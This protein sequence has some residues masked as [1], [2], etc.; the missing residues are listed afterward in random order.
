MQISELGDP[1]LEALFSVDRPTDNG[2]RPTVRL[3]RAGPSPLV[4]G[5]VALAA[6]MLLFWVLESRREAPPQPSVRERPADTSGYISEPPS[7]Y[8]PPAPAALATQISP[9]KATPVAETEAAEKPRSYVSPHTEPAYFPPPP[10]PMPMIQQPS[11]QRSAGGPALVIDTTGPATQPG[12]AQSSTSIA[13]AAGTA[14]TGDRVRASGLANRSTTVPQGVLI[15]AVLETAFDSNR[16]GFARAIVSRDVR[17]FDG[18]QV[19]IPRGSRVI[20]EYQSDVAPGQNRA[21]ITWSRLIRPDGVTI[22][23]NSPSVDP[24]GRGG[25]R[26]SVN[27]HFWER[28]GSALLRS[29]VDIGTGLVTRAATGGVIVAVPSGGQ[30]SPVAPTQYVP[31]LTVRAGTSISIFVARDLEFPPEKQP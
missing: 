18:S 26:A 20:G 4:I 21:L 31:T 29:T 5:V 1:R 30:G 27:T 14:S 12:S 23:L 8:V 16:A 17:G 6:A 22:A 25:V 9:G 10:V 24:L 15:S 7:L 2:V 19:L 3:P 28:F 11:A 13:G